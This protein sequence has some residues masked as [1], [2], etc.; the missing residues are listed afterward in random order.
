MRVF[1]DIDALSR[2]AAE[3]WFARAADSIAARG[4]FHVALAGGG[5]PKHLYEYLSRPEAASK[6][7]WKAVH[8]WMGDERAVPLDHADSNF[9][10]AREA[11]LDHVPIPVEQIHPMPADHDDLELAAREYAEALLR[12]VPTDGTGMPSFDLLLLGMGEDGHTASLFPGTTALEERQHPVVAVY[13]PQLDTWRMSLTLPV[14]D[15]ARSTLLLVSGAAKAGILT[16]VFTRPAIEPRLPVQR[17]EP[18]GEL[19][20]YLDEAAAAELPEEVRSA[21]PRR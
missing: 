16:R 3:Y 7:D 20:W 8:V 2:A 19:D 11:L 13:V 15:A 14:I 6:V 4:A 5:T 21:D 9:R 17:I 12:D 10:M 18:G 1:P